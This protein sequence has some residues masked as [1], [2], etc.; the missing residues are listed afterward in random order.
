MNFLE[1]ARGCV[2]ERTKLAKFAFFFLL[3]CG[4][5]VLARVSLLVVLAFLNVWL[6]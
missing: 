5:F 4:G 2:L 6:V 1:A 3:L